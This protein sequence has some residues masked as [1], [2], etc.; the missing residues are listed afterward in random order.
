MLDVS[1]KKNPEL[2]YDLDSCLDYLKNVHASKDDYEFPE[3]V[4][5]FHLFMSHG[6][7]NVILLETIKSYLATQDLKRT[8]LILWCENLDDSNNPLLEPYKEHIW[9]KSYDVHKEAKGTPLEGNAKLDV[10]QPLYYAQSDL[11]R[12]LITYKY[13]GI[14][15]DMD[16]VF[17]NDFKPILDQEFC[18]EWGGYQPHLDD[19]CKALRTDRYSKYGMSTG[20]LGI[21]KAG[22]MLPMDTFAQ[23][24]MH[25][26]IIN[27]YMDPAT[28]WGKELFGEVWSTW[29][30][31]FTVFPCIFF[32]TEWGSE[33][34]MCRGK[35]LESR[36][37]TYF[38]EPIDDERQMFEYAPFSWHYHNSGGH[39]KKAISTGEVDPRSKFGILR[40]RTNKLLKERGIV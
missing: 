15:M 8:K 6:C 23:H 33:S 35:K 11:F 5:P 34:Q 22:N 19:E 18:Y 16:V 25:Q 36:V 12:I 2:Y 29:G 24:L 3:E 4:V 13:G 39:A 38:D 30:H 7:N 9:F 28:H 31:K 1:F 26:L 10:F 32:N 17:I 37:A 20:A 40:D 21:R 27:K 14:W